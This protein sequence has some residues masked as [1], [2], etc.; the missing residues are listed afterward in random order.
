MRR[1]GLVLAA[2]IAAGLTYVAADATSLPS[3]ALIAWKG[4]GVGLLALY[5]ALNARAAD[6]WLLAAVMAF[7][8]A[9]DVLLETHGF[10]AGGVAFLAGHLVA[11]A[12]YLRNRRAVSLGDL[13]YA[14]ALFVFI[15]LTAYLAPL[16]RT[17]AGPI[18]LYAAALAAMTAS[19]W[20]SRFPRPLV[21]AGAIMFA[22]SDLLIFARAG[23]PN[24]DTPPTGVAVWG[25]YF[26]GQ[27]L[28]TLGAV[29]ARERIAK[30]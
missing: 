28:I 25:L 29:R 12:L 13:T 1:F 27:V 17:T 3:V 26:A 24:L 23:R 7:G 5:A 30:A 21:A 20:L 18:A 2:A 6:G 4:A 22:A 14:G 10:V 9:G 15:V 19:A 8:A 16:N 11:V